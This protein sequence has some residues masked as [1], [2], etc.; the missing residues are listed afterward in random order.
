MAKNK[1]LVGLMLVMMSASSLS[2]C[3]SVESAF[4]VIDSVSNVVTATPAPTATPGPIDEAVS[5]IAISTGIDRISF[6][7]LTGEDWANLIIS[8]LL[9]LLA[10]LIAR[11][12]VRFAL[13]LLTPRLD[14]KH[15]AALLGVIGAP[16]SW[17]LTLFV[18]QFATIRL[19][20]LSPG[21]KMSLGNLY[22]TLGVLLVVY[23]FWR[24]T[25]FA[26]IWYREKSAEV[27]SRASLDPAIVMIRRIVLIFVVLIGLSTLLS[28]FGLNTNALT[29]TLGI[30][31]LALTIA[32]QD[33]LSDAISGFTI[34][35]DQPFRVGDTI[36]IEKISDWGIVT[37]IGLRTTHIQTYDSRVVIIPNSIIGKN[38]VINYSYPDPRYRL[39]TRVRVAYG[40]N[41]K[42]ARELITETIRGVKGVLPDETVK[43]LC[44]EMDESAM[45]LRVWWWIA[46]YKE[47][48][49]VRDRV[50]EAVQ[51]ALEEHGFSIGHPVRELNL[52][53]I[54]ESMNQLSQALG[55]QT[56]EHTS[57]EAN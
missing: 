12:V 30:L 20:F 19:T 24:L 46:D 45:V 32:G 54:P 36:E 21:I 14:E 41:I 48:A 5:G 7:G 28:R 56:E 35:V 6:L 39:E 16:L 55:K 27:D 11:L 15:K 9:V 34:L 44:H 42:A 40:T 29:L 17:L 3:S 31:G 23:L 47:T 50:I 8:L 52:R 49:F 26:E 51:L 13:G 53:V 25:E 1:Y 22:F 38:L 4:T 10:Y 2:A 33:V 43:V 18:L 37:Q 57:S